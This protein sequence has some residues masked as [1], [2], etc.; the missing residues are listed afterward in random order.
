[1]AL[2]ATRGKVSWLILRQGFVVA[3]AGIGMG[4]IGVTLMARVL[5]SLLY[6]TSPGNPSH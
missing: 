2:G 5:R 4:L 6:A 3:L 1:M